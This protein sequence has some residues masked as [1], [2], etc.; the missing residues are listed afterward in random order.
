MAVLLIVTAV[1]VIGC[2]SGNKDSSEQSSL[3]NRES[4]GTAPQMD[5][6]K[7]TSDNAAQ[8]PASAGSAVKSN[9]LALT[10]SAGSYDRKIIY[11]ANITMEVASYGEAQSE[12]K[13]QTL[14]AGGY[15]VQFSENRTAY[16]QSG[17]LTVKVPAAGFTSFITKLEQMKPKS[18]QQNIQGSDV[19]EEFVDLT[20]RLKAKQAVEARL[21]DFLGK[22]AKTDELISFSS[23]LGKVQEEIEKIKGRMTYLEQNVDFSTVEIRLYEKLQAS[24]KQ[25]EADTFIKQIQQT[26]ITSSTII[27]DVMKALLLF[28]SGALPVLLVLAIVGSPLILWL[29]RRRK[30]IILQQQRAQKLRQENAVLAQ[31]RPASDD[32]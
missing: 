26:A 24:K 1:A 10:N 29:R 20:A 6:A 28:A 19:T 17:T 4:A 25:E 30:A 12:I 11:K 27:L 8:E 16:E 7:G 31:D 15:L 32:E 18:I 9:G 5:S 23:E 2:S 13:N 21:L 3:M 22:S 14:L